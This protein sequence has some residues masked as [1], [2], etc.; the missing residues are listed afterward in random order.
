MLSASCPSSCF[1]K[2]SGLLLAFLLVLPPP[3]SRSVAT[4]RCGQE[5]AWRSLLKG[6]ASGADTASEHRE[7]ICVLLTPEDPNW[8]F[9]GRRVAQ[10]KAFQNFVLR[11]MLK[12]YG[13]CSDI[14]ARRGPYILDRNDWEIAPERL[15]KF[16]QHNC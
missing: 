16:L 1:T 2:N 14:E 8:R 13:F 11:S 12:V 7:L 15:A 4:L 10:R 5:A 9:Q 6:K 3:A